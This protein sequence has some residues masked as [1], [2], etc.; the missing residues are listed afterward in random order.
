M[1]NFLPF[2]DGSSTSQSLSLIGKI[3]LILFS[4]ELTFKIVIIS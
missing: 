4:T 3:E 1:G 2:N